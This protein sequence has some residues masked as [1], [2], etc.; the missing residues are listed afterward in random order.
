MLDLKA[1]FDP[2]AAERRRLARHGRERNPDD[3]PGDWRVWWEERAAIMEYDGCLPRERAEALAFDAVLRLMAGS[4]DTASP[5]RQP[6]LS[7][8]Q[9][10][11]NAG[12]DGRSN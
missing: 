4:N 6:A 7:A 11:C 8:A 9:E 12:N 10:N 2:D 3:L 5:G 1:I